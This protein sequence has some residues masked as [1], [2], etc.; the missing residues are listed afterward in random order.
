MSTS[1]IF[2][3]DAFDLEIEIESSLV[4]DMHKL[5]SDEAL[6]KAKVL[7][8]AKALELLE[9]VYAQIDEQTFEDV[10]DADDGPEYCY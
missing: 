10:F 7:A 9:K 1:F 3:T 6:A 5:E 4:G 8:K 2:S